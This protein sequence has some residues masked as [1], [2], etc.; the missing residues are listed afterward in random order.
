VIRV[1]SLPIFGKTV[2]QKDLIELC[3]YHQRKIAIFHGN[4][5][6]RL[7]MTCKCTFVNIMQRH[8][9]TSFLSKL[10]SWILKRL[11]AREINSEG[12][13]LSDPRHTDMSIHLSSSTVVNKTFKARFNILNGVSLD[14]SWRKP[15]STI[16]NLNLQH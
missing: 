9:L 8:F 12:V 16:K 7:K 14:S 4:N 13:S 1:S 3:I 15:F 2:Q 11:V 10:P 5:T 6:T